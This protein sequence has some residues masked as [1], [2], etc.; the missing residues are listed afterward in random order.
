MNKLNQEQLI[1]L[2][3]DQEAKKN[4]ESIQSKLAIAKRVK[5]EV[6]GISDDDITKRLRDKGWIK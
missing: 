6:A 1:Q 4:L 3:R 5:D 2:G